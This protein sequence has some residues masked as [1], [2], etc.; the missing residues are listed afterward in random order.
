MNKSNGPVVLCLLDGFGLS[1]SWRGNAIFSAAPKNFF[2]IWENYPHYLLQYQY[3]HLNNQPA[4]D[5][6]ERYLASLLEG[7]ET[8]S[9]RVYI[10]H[11]IEKDLLKES[12]VLK[13]A[14]KQTFEKN[15][16]LHFIGNLSGG[17]GRFSELKH[18]FALLRLAE[19]NKVFRVYIHL[20]LDDSGGGFSPVLEDLSSLEQ[21]LEKLG[22]G[23]IASVSGLDF[24]ADGEKSFLNFS[25]AY[26]TIV[27]GRGN[28][29]LSAQQ[30]INKNKKTLD[31]PS[32]VPSSVISSQNN[33]IGI[34]SDFDSVVFFN[35]NNS[36]IIKLIL[37]LSSNSGNSKLAQPKFLFLAT[38]FDCLL[39][40]PDEV[41]VIF[42]RDHETNLPQI[43]YKTGLN[44]AFVS[45]STRMLSIKSQIKGMGNVSDYIFEDFLPIVSM[46][47]YLNNVKGTVSNVF[48]KAIDTVERKKYDFILIDIPCIDEVANSGSFKETVAA[49]KAVDYFL[50]S[51]LQSVLGLDGVLIITSNYGNAEK[52]VRRND[53]EALNRRTL[54]PIPF[55]YITNSNKKRSSSVSITSELMYDMVTKKKYL[56]DVAPTILELLGL[57]IPDKFSGHSLMTK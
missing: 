56:I 37:A 29:Y 39:P 57:P 47:A 46:D 2:E 51:L 6:P 49:I 17:S 27:E 11:R 36:Q 21:E 8:K 55:I 33:P 52:M 43:L 22:I 12:D 14:F 20:I 41:N 32:L 38:F 34:I 44:Q 24:L 30:A 48:S 26:R 53:Y 50:P 40:K 4:Y 1:P 15:S 5:N 16:S 31:S 35:H 45:D 3:D 13:K 7:G 18:L 25:K 9:Q 23:E 54:N 19:E 10:D 42:D 28:S